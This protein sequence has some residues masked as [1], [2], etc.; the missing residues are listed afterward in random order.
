SGSSSLVTVVSN[1]LTVGGVITDNGGTL[2]FSKAGGGV[3][4]LGAA[5]TN[6]GTV[7]VSNGVLNISSTGSLLAPVAM[8]GGTL[9]FG[10]A[11][12][13]AGTAG[14]TLSGGSFDSAV[15]NMTLTTTRAQAWSGTIGFIGSN[16][17]NLGAGSVALA[18]S[19]TTTLNVGA[20]LLTLGGII[21]GGTLGKGGLGTLV[22]QGANT[23]SGSL[24][25]G[26]GVVNV[27]NA[28]SLGDTA[29]ATVVGGGASLSLQGGVAIGAE[30]L[31]LSGSGYLGQ[32]G[33]LVNVSDVNSFGGS[34]TLTSG[35]IGVI[36]ADAGSLTLSGAVSGGT[37]MLAGVAAGLITGAISSGSLTKTGVGAWT[38]RPSAAE[39]FAA[40]NLNGGSLLLDYSSISSG[41]LMPVNTIPTFAGGAL[42]LAKGTSVVNTGS[43]AFGGSLVLAAG[44]GQLLVN[45]STITLGTINASAVGG[46]LVLG[47]LAGGAFKSSGALSNSGSFNGRLALFDGANYYWAGTLAGGTVVPQTTTMLTASNGVST[48][49]GSL[50]AGTLLTFASGTLANSLKVTTGT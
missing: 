34:I 15:P 43:L 50:V 48:L 26:A 44:G 12:A 7:T 45:A 6:T 32:S 10:N 41:L 30:P 18:V 35:T 21:S 47:T 13:L 46:G 17:F 11:G 36:S 31:I 33:A 1:T 16:A 2:G 19:G 29:G 23:F 40:L 14:I 3:L 4:V 39:S 24:L 27:Q 38:L 28:L 8:N 37:L 22:L 20:S 9:L 5:S 49:N 25:I 42:Y